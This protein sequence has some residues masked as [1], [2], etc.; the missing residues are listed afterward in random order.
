[1]SA[2]DGRAVSADAVAMTS[3]SQSGAGLLPLF[4]L[5]VVV[6]TVV[7]ALVV[8]EPTMVTMVVALASVIGF[9]AGLVVLLGRLI[10]P[11]EH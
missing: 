9:A 11:D 8:V 6:A 3:E 4:S 1:M 7:I 10:G 2:D 5:A